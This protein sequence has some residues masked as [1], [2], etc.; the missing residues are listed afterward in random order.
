MTT[1]TLFELVSRSMRKNIKQYYL[2]FFALMISVT[3]YFVFAT[4]QNDKSI[5]AATFGDVAFASLFKASGLLLV[6]IVAIFM[7]YA[8]SIFLNRRSKEIGLYQL[9]GLTRNK[10]MLLLIIENMM[11]GLGALVIG[12]GSGALMSRLFLL[13]LMKLIGTDGVIPLH[14]SGTAAFQTAL[15]FAVLIGLTIIQMLFKVYR[16]T[17][18]Q[19]FNSDQQMDRPTEVSEVL[20]ALLGM[21]G[22]VLIVTGYYFSNTLSE[23]QLLMRI[24]ITLVSIILGTFLLFRITIG[25]LFY[26]FRKNRNGQLGLKNSLSL[27]P[28]MHRLKAN[29]SSL[30]LITVLSAMTLTMIAIAY[31]LYY[32]ADSES[33]AMMPYDFVFQNNELDAASFQAKLEN[34]GIIFHQETMKAIRLKG[35]FSNDEREDR[36]V[37][38]LPAEDLKISDTNV[39]IPDPNEAVWYKGQKNALEKETNAIAFPLQVKLKEG[40]TSFNIQIVKDIDRYAMNFGVSGRQLVVAKETLQNIREKLNLKEEDAIVNIKAYRLE[41]NSDQAAASNMYA[42][43]ANAE[44][45]L[46]DFYNYSRE[47]LRKFGLIIF[48]AGF[49]GLVFLIATGSILYFKQMT[50][51]EQEKKSYTILRQLGFNEREIMG[52]IIRKQLFVFA[53]PLIMGMLHSIFAVRTASVLTISDISFPAAIAMAIYTLVYFAFAAL[54]VGYYRR[55]VAEAL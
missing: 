10:V 20:S 15:V 47:S 28:M 9:I 39:V 2:Y 31:S 40:N 3:L 4:L 41:K 29:S 30:T 51:A 14:F 50:E 32:S 44:K 37:L 55:I 52:G 1:L 42:A 48:T 24:T 38:L 33:R 8:N 36:T 11:L 26:R 43:Y 13:I 35:S 18:L 46:P 53:I 5:L 22:I 6:A 16:T 17:L 21:L 12:I 23:G 45:V 49:L 34:E 7:L 19:L 25:W 27:A 54:T